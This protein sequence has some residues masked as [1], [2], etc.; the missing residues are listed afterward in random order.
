MT[1]ATSPDMEDRVECNWFATEEAKEKCK[2]C[3]KRCKVDPTQTFCTVC[4]RT[5]KEISERGRSLN[6]YD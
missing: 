6:A 5:I 2:E 1:Y 3:Q 4:N